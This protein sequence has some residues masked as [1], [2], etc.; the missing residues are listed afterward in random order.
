[1]D[2]A[3]WFFVM[4]IVVVTASLSLVAVTLWLGFRVKEREE[5][6]RTEAVKKIAESSAPTAAIEYLRETDRIY[7]RRMRGGLRLGGL[8]TIAVGIGLML[9]LRALIPERAVYMVGIIP[10]LVGVSLFGFAQLSGN[11]RDG[12]RNSS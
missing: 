9:F 8:V 7:E 2:P 3:V 5:Y 10:L 4:I 12:A 6:Y 1:M 11:S